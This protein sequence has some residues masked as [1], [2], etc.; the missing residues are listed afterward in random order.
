MIIKT[1]SI[2]D[3]EVSALVDFPN[4]ALELG[5]KEIVKFFIRHGTSRVEIER[6]FNCLIQAFAISK[7]SPLSLL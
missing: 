2:F 3:C 6:I 4:I 5:G 7:C 1:Q